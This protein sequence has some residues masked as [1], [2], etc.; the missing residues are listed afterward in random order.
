MKVME[1]QNVAVHVVVRSQEV[2]P[3]TRSSLHPSTPL[4][5]ET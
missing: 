2:V 1:Y 5:N 3:T 4:G